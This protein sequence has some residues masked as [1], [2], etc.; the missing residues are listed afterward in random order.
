MFAK[1]IAGSLLS[2]WQLQPKLFPL[3]LVVFSFSISLRPLLSFALQKLEKK[4][5]EVKSQKLVECKEKRW[6]TIL[7]EIDPAWVTA[8]R[9]WSILVC[10]PC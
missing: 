1:G 4:K 3:L 9:F 6:S 8:K 10:L 7:E 5:K 2:V